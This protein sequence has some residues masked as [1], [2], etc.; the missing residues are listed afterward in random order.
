MTLKTKI[1]SLAVL[2]LLGF[3]CAWES[4]NKCPNLSDMK[5]Q[6]TNFDLTKFTGSWY[7]IMRDGQSPY[8]IMTTCDTDTYVDYDIKHG[9]MLYEWRGFVWW[10]WLSYSTM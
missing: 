4:T 5:N 3:T 7:E 6:M 10:Y 9:K 8:Q 2:S 1:S